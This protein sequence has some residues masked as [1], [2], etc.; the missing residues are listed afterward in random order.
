ME[1]G[2]QVSKKQCQLENLLAENGRYK[3]AVVCSKAR[4]LQRSNRAANRYTHV[5]HQECGEGLDSGSCRISA[6]QP[7]KEMHIGK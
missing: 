2:K 3:S 7:M 4:S 6:L 5:V 1:V